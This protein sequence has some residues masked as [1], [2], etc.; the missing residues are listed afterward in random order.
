MRIRL[1]DVYTV[2][3]IL[4]VGVAIRH[5]L[6]RET[7]AADSTGISWL[8]M[9]TFVAG[10]ATAL[11]YAFGKAGTRARELVYTFANLQ[12]FFGLFGTVLGAYIALHSIDLAVLGTAQAGKNAAVMVKGMG[13]AFWT[14]ILGMAG[15]AIT[16]INYKIMGG[17]SE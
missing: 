7:V 6:L 8:I 3:V 1:Y 12:V 13:T 10:M 15:C 5:G 11:L 2:A 17:E 4:G 14:S 16:Y 9:A